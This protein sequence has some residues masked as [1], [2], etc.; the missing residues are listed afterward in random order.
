MLFPANC[1]RLIVTK[2]KSNRVK[3]L[4]SYNRSTKSQVYT[5]IFGSE[6]I[7]VYC[8]MGNFGCGDGGWT[9]V[10]KID[11][12]KVKF[13]LVF[14]SLLFRFRFA[15]L[16][17]WFFDSEKCF[18]FSVFSAPSITILFFGATKLPTIVQEGRLGLTKRR[19]S[20]QLTGARPSPRSVLG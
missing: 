4:H 2:K 13:I 14:T 5:L 6:T 3:L 12:T 19:R 20:C 18:F 7:P 1:N 17:L 8:H 10:M 11:G 15:L 16:M 9:P